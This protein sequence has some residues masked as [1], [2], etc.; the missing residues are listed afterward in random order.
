MEIVE[1]IPE[2]DGRHVY[3]WG[4]AVLDGKPRKLV[5]GVDFHCQARSVRS[6]AKAYARRRGI[7]CTVRMIRD[8]EV[9][10]QFE[11]EQESVA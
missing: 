4:T 11:D 9:Y 3:D 7:R 10:V 8:R 1:E 6:A 2:A 5:A